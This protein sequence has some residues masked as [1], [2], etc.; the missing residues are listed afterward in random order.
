MSVH[1][2]GGGLPPPP[3]APT[4]WSLFVRH[5]HTLSLFTSFT[6]ALAV[7]VFLILVYGSYWYTCIVGGVLGAVYAVDV[8]GMTAEYALHWKALTDEK[9]PSAL[10]KTY[11][12]YSK[13]LKRIQEILE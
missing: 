3:V 4:A 10:L 11:D 2:H 6:L 12:T 8:G 7:L 1:G 9:R 13:E 5:S